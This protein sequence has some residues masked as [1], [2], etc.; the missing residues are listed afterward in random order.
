MAPDNA[1]AAS[2]CLVCMTAN[3]DGRIP[4]TSEQASPE[5]RERSSAPAGLQAAPPFWRQL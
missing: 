1:A 4:G 5:P 3:D 2:H